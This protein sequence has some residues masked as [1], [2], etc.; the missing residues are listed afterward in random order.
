VS[1]GDSREDKLAD[2][3]RISSDIVRLAGPDSGIREFARIALETLCERAGC[4]A[5]GIR[6]RDE[7]DF[8]FLV[9][10]ALSAGLVNAETSLCQRTHDGSVTR[11]AD[12]AAVLECM[13]G[14]VARGACDPAEPFFTPGGSFWTADADEL[15]AT[16]TEL[17]LQTGFRGRCLREGYRSIAL[18]PIRSGTEVCGVLHICDKR[19]GRV[20]AE[21]V[22]VLER[23]AE[24]LGPHLVERQ[25]L[26][27]LRVVETQYRALFDHMMEGFA[28]CQMHYDEKRR[29]IDWTYLSVNES[30]SHMTGLSDVVGKKVS[31]LLPTI[32]R[33]SPQLLEI[34]GKV[35]S[36][37]STD[38]FE[39]FFAPLDKWLEV[40]AFSL[41]KGRFVAVFSDITERKSTE[42]ALRRTQFSVDHAADTLLWLDSEGIIVDVSESTCRRLDYSRG[43]LIGKTIFDIDPLLPRQS[44]REHW[45]TVKVHGALVFETG[46]RTRN[47]TILSQE[48]TSNYVNF[49]G[50]EYICSFARDVGDRRRLEESLRLTQ[51]SVDHAAD[52]LIWTDSQGVIVEVS[53]STCRNLE[54][55]REELIGRLI[56]D[57][58]SAFP[59]D[60][61]LA[62]W[63]RIKA[64]GSF[65][66]ETVHKTKSGREFPVEVTSNYMEFA[67]KECSCSFS[68]D[69]SKRR[70]AEQDLKQSLDL[71]RTAFHATP[72]GV[73]L[74]NAHSGAIRDANRS[75]EE[76]S[77]FSRDELIGK[78]TT[79]IEFLSLEDRRRFI[80]GIEPTGKIRDHLFIVRN[81][82]GEARHVLVSAESVEL[83][84]KSCILS[85]LHDVT[86]RILSEQKLRDQEE[87][88]RQSQ[89]M[90]A[91]G[92]LAGG[93]AHDFNNALTDRGLQRSHIEFGRPSPDHSGR[94]RG[95]QGGRGARELAHP[96]DSRL[97]APAG[98]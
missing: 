94:R 70:R 69:I 18:V 93:I 55:S 67:G 57:I 60:A 74:T 7:D 71:F 21:R 68:H 73:S 26:E 22:R 97:L 84:G 77:G 96:A 42:E 64:Q 85:F 66:F 83:E 92:Q 43:E 82:A 54:Y 79:E 37:G 30:F 4:R 75:F 35:A 9:T 58:D 24:E 1:R 27:A 23:I 6:L 78:T 88:L 28:Y 52:S 12:G 25:A 32:T 90:E 81:K 45:E 95:D 36:T 14:K 29:P 34:Y 47:G 40:V 10:R 63:E 53:E 62:H 3:D 91:V 39:I 13:C 89:K 48:I 44:W 33:D 76:I 65:A 5:G 15:L 59:S 61:H 11:D 50:R 87:Q 38:R 2:P 80:E 31:D 56:F 51:F 19:K 41:E 98:P 49:D 8:P 20:A 72:V 46:H 17:H 16:T 86:T